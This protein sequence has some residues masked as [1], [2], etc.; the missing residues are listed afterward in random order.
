MSEKQL[1]YMI[2]AEVTPNPATMKFVSNH[3][4]V[5]NDAVYEFSNESDATHAP[6]AARLFSFPFLQKVFITQNFITLTKMDGVEWEDV[7]L[8]LREYISNFLN[9]GHSVLDADATAA[10]GEV[11]EASGITDHSAAE[12]PVE[13]RIIEILDEYIRPAVEG[14]GGAIHFKSFEEGKLNVVLKGACSGCPSSSITLK[15][16]IKALFERMLPEVKEVVAEE[17]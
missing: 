8:E 13:E 11:R 5:V 1:P 2:Y 3:M 6:L 7:M 16:G 9:A 14:D 10:S 12:T 4:L 15:A 17:L